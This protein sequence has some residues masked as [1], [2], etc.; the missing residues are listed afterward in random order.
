MCTKVVED[1]LEER[2]TI[3]GARTLAY[4]T[5]ATLVPARQ[6]NERRIELDEHIIIWDEYPD[7]F[8][9]GRSWPD[10]ASVCLR[11]LA[12]ALTEA[13]QGRPL[14]IEDRPIDVVLLPLK[15]IER[16][17]DSSIFKETPGLRVALRCFSNVSP[18]LKRKDRSRDAKAF[19][20]GL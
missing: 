3:D 2:K 9:N 6:P 20:A 4:L 12:N 17:K 8:Q 1:G 13:A 18:F 14:F 11:K 7:S 19:G 10:F 15:K 16:L 5:G